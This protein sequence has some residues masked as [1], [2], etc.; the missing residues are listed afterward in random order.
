M[1]Q[2][3]KT[4]QT[5]SKIY[6]LYINGKLKRPGTHQY[7]YLGPKVAVVAEK[8]N[9]TVG[10][11][12][13]YCIFQTVMNLEK[14]TM[15][16]R[17]EGLKMVGERYESAWNGRKM[18]KSNDPRWRLPPCSQDRSGRGWRRLAVKFHSDGRLVVLLLPG[19]RMYSGGGRNRLPRLKPGWPENGSKRP[20]WGFRVFWNF[21][22][23]FLGFSLGFWGW[24]LTWHPKL[25]LYRA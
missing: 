13:F 7:P 12:C 20:S 24:I 25:G 17:S 9:P 16:M 14:R 21:L 19:L 1:T 18:T 2:K 8:L 23:G 5:T 6:K 15:E 4:N 10:R 11:I 3:W 22:S